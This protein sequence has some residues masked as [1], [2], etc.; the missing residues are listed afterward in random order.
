MK[1]YRYITRFHGVFAPNRKH[2]E[3]I[4][5]R[6]KRHDRE[7][8]HCAPG[9][10]TPQARLGL[11]RERPPEAVSATL[12]NRCVRRSSSSQPSKSESAPVRTG[13]NRAPRHPIVLASGHVSDSYSSYAPRRSSCRRLGSVHAS[14]QVRSRSLPAA[15]RAARIIREAETYGR[16]PRGASTVSV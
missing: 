12:E 1:L 9:I 2:R 16:K 4:V 6:P 15:G 14:R 7:H 8:H 5:P 13:S 11:S 3:R 10:P